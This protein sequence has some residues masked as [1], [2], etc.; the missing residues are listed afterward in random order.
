MPRVFP[1]QK[2]RLTK[3][4][5]HSIPETAEI[6]F[7]AGDLH[8]N[9]LPVI[10]AEHA[11]KA[12]SVDLLAFGADQDIKGLHHCQGNKRLHLTEGA[13]VDMKFPHRIPPVLYKL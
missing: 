1:G 3:A 2:D 13:N 4:L 6:L 9:R 8:E 11:H 7:R 12:F 10:Q 5:C